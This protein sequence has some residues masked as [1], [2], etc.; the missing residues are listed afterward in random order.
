MENPGCGLLELPD[1]TLGEII[2]L[3]D[4]PDVLSIARCC[5]KLNNLIFKDEDN[6]E[7]KYR[8]V[9]NYIWR[10]FSLRS[11]DLQ[12]ILNL[13]NINRDWLTSYGY[14][15]R[16]FTH[17][18]TWRSQDRYMAIQ[19]N[20]I[21]NI[22]RSYSGGT[23]MKDYL[24]L[25]HPPGSSYSM[26]CKKTDM[27]YVMHQMYQF[28]NVLD[29]IPAEGFLY[30]V[31]E[32]LITRFNLSEFSKANIGME[33]GVRIFETGPINYATHTST[34]IIVSVTTPDMQNALY[35]IKTSPEVF[36]TVPG[37]IH[38]ITI[39]NDEITIQ[40]NAKTVRISLLAA[41]ATHPSQF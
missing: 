8:V 41:L 26:F 40:T 18:L 19:R 1:D 4:L 21:G 30:I 16:S 35:K 13:Y 10:K 15:K 39:E 24:T 9:R 11:Y 23:T 38:A 12:H 7:T 31:E 6:D 32:S 3:V 29:L 2:A 28:R 27:L 34:G 14:T 22:F 33:T 36:A 25:Q 37:Y 17:T 5:K 20:G